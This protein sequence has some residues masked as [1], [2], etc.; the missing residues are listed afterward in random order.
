MA[1][2]AP[3]YSPR[4]PTAREDIEREIAAKHTSTFM[5]LAGS[6]LETEQG[7]AV[8]RYGALPPNITDLIRAQIVARRS[9]SFSTLELAVCGIFPTVATRML[10][11]VLVDSLGVRAFALTDYNPWGDD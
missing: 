2:P 4:M 6:P 9:S 3:Q 10:V 8:P 7:F 11:R 1:Y 5:Q